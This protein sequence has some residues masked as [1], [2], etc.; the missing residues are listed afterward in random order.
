MFSHLSIDRLCSYNYN[1]YGW[2]LNFKELYVYF[3]SGVHISSLKYH[4]KLCIA[5]ISVALE[6]EDLFST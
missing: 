5:L 2:S 1:T 6:E 3:V 4:D